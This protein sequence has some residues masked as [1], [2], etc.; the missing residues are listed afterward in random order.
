M[1][2][3]KAEDFIEHQFGNLTIIDVYKKNGR[4]YCKCLCSCGK[5]TETTF[6][7]LRTGNTTSCGDY[8]KHPRVKKENLI[9]QKFN[10]LTVLKDTNKKSGSHTIWEC[11]CDCGNI[12]EVR[13]DYLKGNHTTS[14]GC[15]ISKGEAKI[16]SLLR[17]NGINFMMHRV[18]SDCIFPD[19]GYPAIFDFYLEPDY[20]NKYYI[21]C[22]Y[23]IEFDGIQH[24][25]SSNSGWNN[26]ENLKKTKN[27]DKIKNNY[28]KNHNIPLIRIPYTHLNKLCLKDLLLE[29][30]KYILEEHNAE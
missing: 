3:I 24:F 9:G 27:N 8:K 1:K 17:E 4:S 18:V 20:N 23:Y 29:T 13:G 21:D 30:S 16:A 10:K 26:E 12:V 2:K 14:C 6:S 7:N 5:E 11:K 25:E 28:C 22:A 19:T 15:I